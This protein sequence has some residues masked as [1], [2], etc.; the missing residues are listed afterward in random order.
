MS[1]E[2]S[3]LVF[4]HLSKPEIRRCL[5]CSSC[6]RERSDGAEHTTQYSDCVADHNRGHHDRSCDPVSEGLFLRSS[7][8]SDLAKCPMPKFVGHTEV[9]F[10][11]K[12][13]DEDS[14]PTLNRYDCCACRERRQN[15]NGE[16]EDAV[17]DR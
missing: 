14:I 16:P 2:N 13:A 4:K 3:T 5:G 8:T 10:A 7:V 15:A 6:F 17:C 12:L 9:R 1:G 11:L